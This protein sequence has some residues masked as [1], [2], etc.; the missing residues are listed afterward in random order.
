MMLMQ[1]L[2]NSFNKGVRV[3]FKS[4]RRLLE[5]KVVESLLTILFWMPGIIQEFYHFLKCS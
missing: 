5:P 1:Q 3:D 4:K 2:L